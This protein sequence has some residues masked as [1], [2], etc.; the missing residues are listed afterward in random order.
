MGDLEI[1]VVAGDQVHGSYYKVIAGRIKKVVEGVPAF[2][3]EVDSCNKVLDK[4]L[5]GLWMICKE[6]APCY[7]LIGTLF[8]RLDGPEVQW[9]F[10]ELLD[11]NVDVVLGEFL[12][13][14]GQKP[15]HSGLTV[16]D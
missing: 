12:F 2:L 4:G 14:G 9:G 6:G 8:Q 15:F 3:E 7:H 10:G 11:E 13:P 5:I 1:F 16:C